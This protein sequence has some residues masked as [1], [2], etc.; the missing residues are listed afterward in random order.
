[1]RHGAS[2]EGLATQAVPRIPLASEPAAA[3]ERRWL[4]RLQVERIQDTPLP[5]QVTGQPRTRHPDWLLHAAIALKPR[6]AC[7]WRRSPVGQMG[8]ADIRLEEPLS[9][10]RSWTMRFSPANDEGQPTPEA[11]GQATYL[12]LDTPLA[13]D[14][15][16]R[17]VSL[18]FAVKVQDHTAARDVR[19]LCSGRV[20]GQWCRCI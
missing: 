12:V 1:M 16:G 11:P 20:S 13:A 18:L 14:N 17:N 2:T 9:G 3:G 10:G 6:P 15:I 19:S 5:P 4:E 7:W 8:S